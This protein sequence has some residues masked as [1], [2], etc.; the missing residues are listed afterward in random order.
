MNVSK[1]PKILIVE[2]ERIV[3]ADLQQTLTE[4]GYDVFATASSS[5]EAVARATETCPDVVL[6]DIRIKGELDGI[7]TAEIL[8]DRFRVI[9]IFLTAHADVAMIE[10]AKKAEPSGYLLKPVNIA[11]LRSAIEIAVYK[12]ELENSRRR[13]ETLE[14]ETRELQA[15]NHEREERLRALA[16]IANGV[17][18]DIHNALT[19]ASVYAESLLEQSAGLSAKSKEALLA[20]QNAIERVVQTVTRIEGFYTE[21][22]T[23]SETAPVN[24]NRLVERALRL[25]RIEINTRIQEQG[26]EVRVESDVAADVMQISTPE[27]EICVA[28]R[29]LILNAVDSMPSRGVLTLRTRVRDPECVHLEVTD[30]GTGM[31]AAMRARCQ[32]PYFTSK[33]AP[34]SGVGLGMVYGMLRRH[35]G[36]L[37]IDSEPGKG[38]TMRLV[39]T[40]S[41]EV[42]A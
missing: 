37:Q 9:I 19:P 18:H 25:A 41:R 14:S 34:G 3:A 33:V 40:R 1:S 28:L 10:R 2:D 29:V 32:E 6:M 42:D 4:L 31:D 38:T 26:I 16:Q 15:A 22:V 13:A 36:E 24:L 35:G 39:L 7:Q 20:I 23:Q 27:T 11:E 21:R 5:Q 8:R 30:T 17:A 12:R